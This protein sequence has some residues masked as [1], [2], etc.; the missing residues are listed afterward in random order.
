MENETLNLL[1]PPPQ[2]RLDAW[3]TEIYGKSVKIKSRTLLRHRDLSFVERLKLEDAMPATLIYKVVLPPWDV[4]QDLHEHILIPSVSNSARLYLSGTYQGTFAMFMED[5][6]EVTLLESLKTHR[7]LPSRLGTELA[8]LHRAFTYRIPEVRDTGVL[9]CLLPEDF[10]AMAQEMAEE[11]RRWRII[12]TEDERLLLELAELLKQRFKDEPI[13]L[14]HGDLYAENLLFDG[15]H[16]FIIDWSWFTKISI[17][18]IDLATVSMEHFKN[19]E[20]YEHHNEIIEAYCQ[21]YSRKL[22][23]TYAKL[24]YAELASRMLFL[25][26]L[27]ERRRRGIMGTTVGP[28]DILIATVVKE[29]GMRLQACKN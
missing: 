17:P 13:S 8:K 27:V 15:E 9:R 23:D 1:T 18:I 6:G 7:E 5:L 22:D 21:E 20:L 26:W 29:L 19:A 14:V 28:V 3:L 25:E 4:E 10:P 24:P 16:I 11:M 12:Q 2:E